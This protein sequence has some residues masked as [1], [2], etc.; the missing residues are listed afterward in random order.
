M[1]RYLLPKIDRSQ[2]SQDI[3]DTGDKLA[4]TI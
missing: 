4:P 3:E 2:P 1:K